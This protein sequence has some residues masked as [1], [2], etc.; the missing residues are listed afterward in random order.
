M[1][2]APYEGLAFPQKRICRSKL[3]RFLSAWNC[4]LATERVLGVIRDV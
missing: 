1:P 2:Q 3:N 4:C